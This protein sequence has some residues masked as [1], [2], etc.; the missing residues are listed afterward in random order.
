MI[1]LILGGARSG[2]SEA[3]ERVAGRLGHTVTFVA[4]GWAHD[5]EMAERIAIH[6]RRRPASWSTVEV[7]DG[8]AV[9]LA[10]LDGPVLVDALGT[11]LAR[12]AHFEIDA[13]ELCRALSERRGDTVVVSDEVGMGVHPSSETGRR[14]RDALGVLNH[15]VA[16]VSDQVLLVMAGRVLHLDRP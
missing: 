2:K 3:A 13:G 9:A 16:D 12:R 4:T 7:D 14:F 10:A 6:R 15:R 1:T 5:A 8:L 11:W